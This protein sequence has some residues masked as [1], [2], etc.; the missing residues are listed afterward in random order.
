M[1]IAPKISPIPQHDRGDPGDPFFEERVRDNL[2]VR[3]YGRPGAKGKG[4][5]VLHFHGGAFIA[6]DLESGATVAR[7]LASTGAVVVSL[8]YPLAPAYPFPYAIEAGYAALEWT[9]QARQ[10]LAGPRA[11]LFVAGEEAGGNLAA[12]MALMVRDRL[13]PPLAGQILL[14]PMLDACLGTASLRRSQAGPATC[15][16][17]AGWRQ[18]LQ[19]GRGTD[20]PYAMPGQAQRL[21]GLPPALV[22]TA[23]DDPL[24][25]EAL[26]YCQRL[27]EAGVP[28]SAFEL[29]KTTGWPATLGEGT[30]LSAPWAEPVRGAFQSFLSE[31][32]ADAPPS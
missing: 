13:F 14:S 28:A 7:L 11:R 22:V 2:T 20:H 32:G 16:W 1:S 9:W 21:A 5:L 19:D 8:D 25:D 18:Y 31:A 30:G 10:R 24:H 12:A 26:T 3:V 27:D 4:A 23:D 15:R 17:A 6:G 29:E